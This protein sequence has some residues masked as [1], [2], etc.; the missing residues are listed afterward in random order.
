MEQAGVMEIVFGQM[1]SARQVLCSLL[2]VCL[3]RRGSISSTYLLTQSLAK[4][5]A[6]KFCREGGGGG[7]GVVVKN[8]DPDFLTQN[9]WEKLFWAQ[10]I[11]Q[12]FI[13]VDTQ[14]KT[15]Q[16]ALRSLTKRQF[17]LLLLH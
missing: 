16:L 9:T 14:P 17:F 3:V 11:I 8:I 7:G 13:V 1:A 12:V 4:I 5:L 6:T 2:T 15:V 10:N